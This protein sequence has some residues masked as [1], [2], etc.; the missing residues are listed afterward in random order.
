MHDLRKQVL[1]ESKKTTSRKARS[2]DTSPPLSGNGSATASPRGSRVVSRAPSDDESEVSDGTEATSHSV[3]ALGDAENEVE[4][5]T[6]ITSL[7][8]RIEAL[9]DRKR[10]STEGREE[11]IKSI[12]AI[13]RK[14][15]AEAELRR[16]MDEL[17]PALL[18]SVKSGQSED[19]I[20]LALKTLALIV[21]TEPSDAI[22]DALEGPIKHIMNDSEYP[23]AKVAAIRALGMVTFYGGASEEGTLEVMEL[24]LDIISSDGAVIDET[25]NG[26]VVVAALEEWGFLATQ[27]EDIQESN[28]AAMEIFADQLESS[29]VAVQ[30]AAGENIALLYEKS[31]TEAESGD[32]P[33]DDDGSDGD[34]IRMVKRYDVYRQSRKLEQTLERMVKDSCK[35]IAKKDRKQLH[36]AFRDILSTVEKPTRGPRYSTATDMEDREYGSRMKVTI[37]GGGKMVINKW[38]KLHRLNRIKGLLQN[39]FMVHYQL[40]QTIFDSLPVMVERR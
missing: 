37:P 9:V 30:I 15:F 4:D 11:M 33:K 32:E 35:S 38:W 1:L 14:H 25:D 8:Q 3:D 34:G 17:L 28:E 23:G 19:E 16:K 36:V 27:I 2:K 21:I 10:S 6:W 7:E 5:D 26:K 18:K 22:F 31:Y 20:V 24:Y 29:D 12:I 40:N 39:G 13:L